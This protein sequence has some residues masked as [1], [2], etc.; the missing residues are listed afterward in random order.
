MIKLDRP[1]QDAKDVFVTCISRVRDAQLK[2][3]LEGVTQAVV[4]ASS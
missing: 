1:I 4:D 2:A 3:R